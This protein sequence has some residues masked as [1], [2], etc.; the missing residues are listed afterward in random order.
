[1]TPSPRGARVMAVRGAGTAKAV[2]A[3]AR[4]ER[5]VVGYILAD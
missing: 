4:T 3:R 1:M 2:E 5:R